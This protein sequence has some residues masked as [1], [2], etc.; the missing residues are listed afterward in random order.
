MYETQ[1]MDESILYRSKQRLGC[2]SVMLPLYIP[3]VIQCYYM[4]TNTLLMCKFLNNT[5]VG[6]KDTIEIQLSVICTH[7]VD[8]HRL[9]H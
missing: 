9:G 6:T 3:S 5:T 8:F 1:L 4:I 2:V 7:M